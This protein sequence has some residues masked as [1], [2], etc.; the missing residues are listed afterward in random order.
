MVDAISESQAGYDAAIDYEHQREYAQERGM[1]PEP[2]GDRQKILMAEISAVA[3]DD[4]GGWTRSSAA[5][6]GRQRGPRRFPA[7]FRSDPF[8]CHQSFFP[9]PWASRKDRDSARNHPFVSF[10]RL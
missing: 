2:P 3:M 4:N 6:L 7:L 5:K 9:F 1:E 8:F 10:V